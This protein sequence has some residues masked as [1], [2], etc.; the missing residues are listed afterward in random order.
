V[1][2]ALSSPFAV[3]RDH[4]I[5][6]QPGKDTARLLA[7]A[8][9]KVVWLQSREE[10]LA[11]GLAAA[12]AALP[13]AAAVVVEGNAAFQAARADLGL[14]VIGA[15]PRPLKPSVNVALPFT[16][17]VV[18]NA[19]PGLPPPT[20][21][22][23]LPSGVPVFTFDAARPG[24]QGEAQSFIQWV[25]SRLGLCPAERRVTLATGG[26]DRGQSQCP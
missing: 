20:V 9:G 8:P 2:G 4:D 7:A 14:L 25:A 16:D 12:L 26:R 1:C 19:R 10:A 15:G 21:M 11:D 3:I 18:L 6:A 13:D 22:D 5:L 17:V 24:D 23:G